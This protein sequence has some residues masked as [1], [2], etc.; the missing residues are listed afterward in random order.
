MEYTYAT[1]IL[2]ETGAE[3]NEKNITAVLE[4]AGATVSESRV[5]AHV[6]ALEGVDVADPGGS[7]GETDPEPLEGATLSDDEDGT[8]DGGDDRTVHSLSEP[9]LEPEGGAQSRSETGSAP[10]GPEPDTGAEH[11]GGGPDTSDGS[12][13]EDSVGDRE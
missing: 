6:A 12:N 8:T 13:S 5:R 3:L 2:E 4:A 7:G 9:E 1:L 11:S 10:D